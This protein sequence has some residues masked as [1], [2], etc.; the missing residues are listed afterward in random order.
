[1]EVWPFP[2]AHLPV[3]PRSPAP[4]YHHHLPLSRLEWTTFY[5]YLLSL[6]F[7]PSLTACEPTFSLLCV[8]SHLIHL[9]FP[10]VLD[11]TF[12]R[13]SATPLSPSIQHRSPC[14]SFLTMVFCPHSATHPDCLHTLGRNLIAEELYRLSIV[15]SRPHTPCAPGSTGSIVVRGDWGLS[16]DKSSQFRF[17]FWFLVGGSIAVFY[18]AATE[19]VPASEAERPA[20]CFSLPF[21]FS[22]R[23]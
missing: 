2:Y 9:S 19:C 3:L 6:L 14:P 1:M 7:S 13:G 21:P 10:Q 20:L 18:N 15:Q 23:D 12:P 16:E 4:V 22:F 11:P 17:R 5:C 8:R